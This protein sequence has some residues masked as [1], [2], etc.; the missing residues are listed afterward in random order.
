MSHAAAPGNPG[1]LTLQQASERL[2]VHP[3]TLRQWA[4]RGRVRSFRTPGGHRRFSAE[5]VES[6]LATL[7]TELP[8]DLDLLL[9][10]A[11]GRTRREL[12]GGALAAETWSRL[13][14]P[15]SRDRCRQLGRE[16]VGLVVRALA[17]GADAGPA[18]AAARE[19]AREQGR[20]AAQ[21]GLTVAEAVRAHTTFRAMLVESVFQVKTVQDQGRPA[22]D[23]VGCH[24]QVGAFLDEVLV[25]YLDAFSETG[26]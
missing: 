6:L 15:V 8:P 14:D 10:A 12:S 22:H 4:D 9:S 20:L 16:L 26:R 1:W 5:D 2:D 17:P 21:A 3:A 11:L 18:L 19:G 23:L 25:A 7:S 24:R 13:L